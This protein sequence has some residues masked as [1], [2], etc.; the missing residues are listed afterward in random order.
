MW[1]RILQKL[2]QRLEELGVLRARAVGHAQ[3]AGAPQR[4]AG[5][6]EHAALGQ[7]VDDVV[8]DVRARE[9]E[10]R[11]VGL[12]LGGLEAEVAQARV[13]LQ[14]GGD[15]A[16]D[17]LGDLILVLERLE[18]GGLREAVAEERLADL[19]DGLLELR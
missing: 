14:A 13:D 16:L 6:D 5:A 12:R 10:P 15:R 2:S 1:V 4:L 3:R 8:L 17:A 11:E 18:R 7:A 9:V 19:V